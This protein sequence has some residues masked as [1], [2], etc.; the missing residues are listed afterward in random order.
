MERIIG[1][2]EARPKLTAIIDSL[3]VGSEPVILTVNSEPKSV[4][5]SYDEYCRLRDAEKECKKLSLKLALQ[6]I[7]TAAGQANISG[8]DVPGEVQA[9]RNSRKGCTNENSSGH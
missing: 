1:I 5:I 2:N 4:L 9:L 7:R 8:Q 6:K 3:V